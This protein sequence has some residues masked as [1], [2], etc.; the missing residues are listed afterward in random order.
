MVG[1]GE[2]VGCY[3]LGC[4]CGLKVVGTTV[5]VVEWRILEMC[6]SFVRLWVWLVQASQGCDIVSIEER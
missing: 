6:G 3:R 2:R 1:Q 4:N 5:D